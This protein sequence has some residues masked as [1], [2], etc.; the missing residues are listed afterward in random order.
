MKGR[1]M[2]DEIPKY[3]MITTVNAQITKFT[4]LVLGLIIGLLVGY[5]WL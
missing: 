4:Y 5:I 3:R 2:S 1:Q